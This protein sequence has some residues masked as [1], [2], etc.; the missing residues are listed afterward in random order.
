MARYIVARIVKIYA[1]RAPINSSIRVNG[2][3]EIGAKI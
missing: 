2:R 3:A 1:C